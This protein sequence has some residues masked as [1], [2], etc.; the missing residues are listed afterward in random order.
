[1]PHHETGSLNFSAATGDLKNAGLK[2]HETIGRAPIQKWLKILCESY[3]KWGAVQLRFGTG[4]E[5]ETCLF[6]DSNSCDGGC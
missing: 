2:F 1:M 6:W 5:V 4:N 3:L